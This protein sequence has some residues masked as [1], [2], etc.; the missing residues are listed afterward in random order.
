MPIRKRSI[1]TRP[2]CARIELGGGSKQRK[3]AKPAS[4][5]ADPFVREKAATKRRLGPMPQ[6]DATL[7]VVECSRQLVTLCR[8]Q[9]SEIELRSV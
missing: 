4:K 5:R 3:P 8:G 6:Q 2:A 7:F 9:R 1:E